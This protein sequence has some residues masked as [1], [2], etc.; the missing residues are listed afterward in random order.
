MI[1]VTKVEAYDIN[2]NN[3]I[4][5]TVNNP[6]EDTLFNM[7]TNI[8]TTM[9]ELYVYTK[10]W[11]SNG[12]FSKGSNKEKLLINCYPKYPSP[13]M[14]SRRTTDNSLEITYQNN[15]T[16]TFD[17]TNDF[18]MCW[19][20]AI[21]TGSFSETEYDFV[22]SGNNFSY[23]KTLDTTSKDIY[24]TRTRTKDKNGTYGNYSSTYVYAKEGIGIGFNDGTND[25]LFGHVSGA[26]T[27]VLQI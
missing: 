19:S 16:A 18:K 26:D 10:A 11:L 15:L 8:T 21:S 25:I 6:P 23:V 2:N 4:I 20:L 13:D 22:K 14:L 9:Y 12:F 3:A 17:I 5:G 24:I 1:T 7:Q 27:I